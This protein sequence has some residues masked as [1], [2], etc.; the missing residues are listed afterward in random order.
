M[1]AARLSP[2]KWHMRYLILI[3]STRRESGR[4]NGRLNGSLSG[5]L[6]PGALWDRAARKIMKIRDRAWMNVI[7][8]KDGLVAQNF[9]AQVSIKVKI[10]TCNCRKAQ[11][12]CQRCQ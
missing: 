6:T 7:A 8:E 4:L 9:D 11:V 2:P 3:S 10:R 12:P 1:R 5:R